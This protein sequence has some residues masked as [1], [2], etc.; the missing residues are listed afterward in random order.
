MGSRIRCFLA[1]ETG[2]SVVSLRR[3]SMRKCSAGDGEICNAS[4]PIYERRTKYTEEGFIE[5]LRKPPEDCPYWPTGCDRCGQPFEPGDYWQI[6][7]QIIFEAV[8]ES[9]T[10]APPPGR[11]IERELPPG[12]MFYSTWAQGW[13][14]NHPSAS[15]GKVLSVVTP[16]GVWCIDSESTNGTPGQAGWTR[17]GSPPNVTAKPSI[18]VGNNRYHGFLT[19]GYLDEC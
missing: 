19:D 18:M 11:W 17:T 3:Y 4:R 8:G 1:E 2:F 15:D 9:K 12:A 14:N 6:N 7:Q 13:F 16:A 5:P 10:F